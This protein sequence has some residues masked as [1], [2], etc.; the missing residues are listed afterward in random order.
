MKVKF[1]D[2]T[3]KTGLSATEQKI[4]R[5]GKGIGWML[6]LILSDE[7]TAEALDAT[8]TADNIANII[9]MPDDE[10]VSE[11]TEAEAVG[12]ALTGYDTISFSN[13]RYFDGTMTPRAEIRLTKGV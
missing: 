12:Y 6:T 13:L 7:L 2:G 1:N 9:L 11:T 4:F 8:L 5:E 10:A 3:I